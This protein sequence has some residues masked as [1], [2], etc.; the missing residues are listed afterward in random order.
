MTGS[1]EV[2]VPLESL[3]A[4]VSFLLVR[5]GPLS[6]LLH[7]LTRYERDDHTKRAVWLG[8]P[9]P[10]RLD[11]LRD[12]LGAPPLQCPHLGLGYSYSRSAGVNGA[13]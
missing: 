6:V 10:L 9:I 13:Q 5:R 8:S 4:F 11:V 3:A 7:P 12:D 1:Y 2:W